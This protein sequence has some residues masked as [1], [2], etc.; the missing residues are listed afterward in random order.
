MKQLNTYPLLKKY[1]YGGFNYTASPQYNYQTQLPNQTNFQFQNPNPLSQPNLQQP[2]Y[3]F[4]NP[5]TTP[6]T[7]FANTGTGQ[8]LDQNSGNLAGGLG[9]A[10][11]FAP[12]GS[13]GQSLLMGAGAGA[14]VGSL[15]GPLGTI[16]GGVL[17]GVTSLFTAGKERR[18]Q[19]RAERKARRQTRRN[20]KLSQAIDS[21][22]ILANYN[23]AGTGTMDF[24][25]GGM[26]PFP[27]NAK[28]NGTSISPT[29]IVDK[30]GSLVYQMGGTIPEMPQE[31]IQ[32]YRI[33]ENV[34][35]GQLQPLSDSAVVVKGNDPNVTDNVSID[36]GST[37]VDHNEVLRSKP[38]GVDILS[39]TLK[40]PGSKNTFAELAKKLEKQKKEHP[41]FQDSN[42][43]IETKL[44]ELFQIQQLM[45]GDSHGEPSNVPTIPGETPGA[46][47]DPQMNPEASMFMS[48]GQYYLGGGT[49]DETVPLSF[50]Y[51]G[52]LR[53][54]T[55]PSH[56]TF[57]PHWRRPSTETPAINPY[58]T[59]TTH[60]Q[61]RKEPKQGNTFSHKVGTYNKPI[62]T[63]KKSIPKK[64]TKKTSKKIYTPS[65]DQVMNI[66][67]N[68]T[69]YSHGGYSDLI[70]QEAAHPFGRVG[71]KEGGKNTYQAG[72]RSL[73]GP[74]Q[75]EY[76][77]MPNMGLTPDY[78]Q[79]LPE[80]DAYYDI[81]EAVTTT[82]RSIVPT[83]KPLVNPGIVTERMGDINNLV[84][85]PELDNRLYSNPKGM[86]P[87]HRI[88]PTATKRP[89]I[90]TAEFTNGTL[91][92]EQYMINTDAGIPDTGGS[93]RGKRRFFDAERTGDVINAASMFGEYLSNKRA[94]NSMPEIPRARLQN[95]VRLKNQNVNDQLSK[96]DRDFRTAIK[97][98]TGN[99]PTG[100][101]ADS[102]KSS[103]LA[104]KLEADN[105]AINRVQNLNT[106]ID[107]QETAMNL[108]VGRANVNRL[109]QRDRDVVS[110]DMSMLRQ[111]SQNK[112][113][114]L[115]Q[116]RG[117]IGERSQRRRDDKAMALRLIAD[118]SGSMQAAISD[119][120]E[121][122]LASGFSKKKIDTLTSQ[123]KEI[124]KEEKDI[125]KRNPRTKKQKDALQKRIARYEKK[126]GKYN[127]LLELELQ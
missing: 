126:L 74:T 5:T 8:W 82:N 53:G 11:T 103:L 75:P 14:A 94:I 93:S 95:A 24:K 120:K 62:V 121:F 122:L 69:T 99:L 78:G 63:K 38:D 25:D 88:T 90:G 22:A 127:S 50:K 12:E 105:T 86:F 89:L 117:S 15:F 106:Q 109:Q 115:T 18:Q 64:V 37:F 113:N 110:R 2:N 92:P 29:F 9:A 41:L 70:G 91:S 52:K 125:L 16:A 68:M 33:P 59:I 116:L 26:I 13:R 47:Y 3:S 48:G 57:N 96:S 100:A 44:E 107:N 124:E 76:M 119:N 72:G 54:R 30:K 34:Q 80:R 27:Y 111:S 67:D 55:Q 40:P 60:T 79:R 65:E 46:G 36:N 102:L 87:S 21:N 28:S 31:E 104:K 84:E 73:I 112:A 101:T 56:G 43:R 77:S 23:S 19:K 123:G 7:G 118:T 35:G 81:P 1:Q 6:Q 45:N 42:D 85:T 83:R 39:D 98:T 61:S 10:A 114:L 58:T 108:D 71:Y 32:D 97:A 66:L 20:N 49:M 17:G 51:G 4:P